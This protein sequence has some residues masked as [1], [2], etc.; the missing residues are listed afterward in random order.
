MRPMLTPS[1][2]SRPAERPPDAVRFT[3]ALSHQSIII[4]PPLHFTPPPSCPIVRSHP[5]PASSPPRLLTHPPQRVPAALRTSRRAL[6]ISTFK[7]SHSP[8]GNPALTRPHPTHHHTAPPNSPPRPRP[9]LS[10]H[11]VPLLTPS[12]LF[13]LYQFLPPRPAPEGSGGVRTGSRSRR[14][15]ARPACCCAPWPAR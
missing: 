1:P 6:F 4:Q 14:R 15:A 10:L 7:S 11:Y 9:P 5:R 2:P 13:L 12:P 3:T 8:L